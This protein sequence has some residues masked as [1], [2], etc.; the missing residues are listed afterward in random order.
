MFSTRYL[1]SRNRIYNGA[2]YDG[3]NPIGLQPGDRG[4][5]NVITC[6]HASLTQIHKIDI[7]HKKPIVKAE[8][9]IFNL[10]T[11]HLQIVPMARPTTPCISCIKVESQ[12]KC[13]SSGTHI[14]LAFESYISNKNGRIYTYKS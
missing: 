9:S 10:C 6:T 4:G 11:S 1:K 5:K 14:H 3:N 13:N 12:E 7:S 2:E 8:T